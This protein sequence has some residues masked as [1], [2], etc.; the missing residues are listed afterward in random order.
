MT[1][2]IQT[3]RV[4][5]AGD[6]IT[7]TFQFA[8]YVP[9]NSD[10]KVYVDGSLQTLGTDYTMSNTYTES[11]GQI[12][13]GAAP[14]VDT[15]VTLQRQIA[16][17]QILD[18]TAYDKFPAETIEASLD[19]LVLLI[20]QNASNITSQ[21]DGTLPGD[22]THLEADVT[23][24]DKYTQ[25]QVDALITG[26]DGSTSIA[27]VQTNL[28]THE[29][30]VTNPHSVTYT[31]TGGAAASHTHLEANVTDLDKYTQAEVDALL[32]GDL[33]STSLTLS[34]SVEFAEMGTAPTAVAD[35]A[36]LFAQD[37]GSGKTQ[38]MV[39][40]PTGSAIQIA[41]EV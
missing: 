16:N 15:T 17:T 9:N 2:S 27:A 26:V 32:A 38:L 1:I 12:V 19:R 36:I 34:E 28:D 30:D 35:K 5:Y 21:L 4:Q 33:S 31:Q 39:Q 41:I 37:N 18:L 25:A 7:T 40:F 14:A 6:A 22:H 13:L 23:D 3:S 10:L 29:A 11:G 24:L 20:Q 8:F